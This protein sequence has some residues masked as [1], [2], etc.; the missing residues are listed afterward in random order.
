MRCCFGHPNAVLCTQRPS[1]GGGRIPKEQE[2]HGNENQQAGGDHF[3]RFRAGRGRR[4]ERPG[5]AANPAVAGRASANGAAH[6][7]RFGFWGRPRRPTFWRGS[8]RPP[9]TL[10]SPPPW[11]PPSPH[12]PAD[13]G[14]VRK[15]H[16]GA[17]D[18]NEGR[19]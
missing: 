6:S 11:T 8:R 19:F 18:A 4:R 5:D 14:R 7:T 2:H 1:S 15:T 12:E 9:W 10:A 13:E 16:A 3:E 17:K